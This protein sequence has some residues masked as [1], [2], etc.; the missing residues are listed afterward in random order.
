MIRLFTLLLFA[1]APLLGGCAAI[2]V[3][4]AATAGAVHDRRSVGTVLDDQTLE[5]AVIDSIYRDRERFGGTR[6]K[7]VTHNG[8]VL[9]IGEVFDEALKARAAEL[10]LELQGVR[11]VVN[12][13]SI[14]DPPGLW[15]RSAD[16][17]LTSRVK[18]GL[19]GIDLPGFDASRINVTTVR[20][21]VYLMG[22]VRR[23]EADAVVAAVVGMRGVRRVVKVFEYLD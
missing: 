23:A 2:L 1:L 18:A 13:L 9:L 19:L 21:E 20:G 15:R 4:G 12:E 17:A 6:I 8:V 22:L 14:G 11:R 10:A 5:I 7:A 3:G 16:S